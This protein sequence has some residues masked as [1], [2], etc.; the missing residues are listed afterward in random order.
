MTDLAIIERLAAEINALPPEDRALLLAKVQL[1]TEHQRT[2]EASLQSNPDV[3][4]TVEEVEE[5]LRPPKKRLT[6]PEIVAAG[7]VGGWEHKGITDSVEWLAAQRRSR[8]ERNQ[9]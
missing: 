1:A 5:L 4:L 9:W 6:G 3:V 8:R 2:I 7:L